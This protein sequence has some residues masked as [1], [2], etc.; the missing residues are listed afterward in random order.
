MGK[1]TIADIINEKIEASVYGVPID[2]AVGKST[3]FSKGLSQGQAGTASLVRTTAISVA[4]KCIPVSSIVVV[5]GGGAASDK[6]CGSGDP[7][8]KMWTI[9]LDSPIATF[10]ESVTS[11][12]ELV[13]EAQ[14]GIGIFGLSISFS[15]VH[16]SNGVVSGTVVV[17]WEENIAGQRVVIIRQSLPFSIRGRARI[18]EDSFD[19]I[20]GI[21]VSVYVEVYAQ[22]NPNS[23]CVEARA[24]WP[25]GNAGD[26]HCEP[27]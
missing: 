8:E 18:Y 20:W 1:L 16:E 22:L 7:D 23:V 25:G 5:F 4:G 2:A 19:V 24:R 10:K 12:G 13:A 17:N 3:D 15:G 26:T 9:S 11:L 14:G 27:F 21:R 6:K